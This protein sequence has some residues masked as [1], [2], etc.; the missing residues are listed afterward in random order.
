MATAFIVAYTEGFR[1]RARVCLDSVRKH[2]PSAKLEELVIENPEF[3]K[4][5]YVKGLARL[6][7]IKAREALLRNEGPVV[8]IGADCVFYDSI[9]RLLRVSKR[10]QY[11][12]S[13][14]PHVL[15][16]LPTDELLPNMQ[17]VYKTGHAN[18]D[19]IIFYPNKGAMEI[20]DWLLSVPMENRIEDGIFYEQNW[21]SALPFLFDGV[22]I[23][24]HPGYNVAY[25][26]AHEERDLEDVVFVQYSGYIEGNP[27]MM[28]KHNERF[29]ATG[30]LLE[31]FKEYEEAIK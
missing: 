25:F 23:I 27:A 6:R 31:L 3:E 16:P 10:C 5:G 2:H 1:K 13:I 15:K 12:V 4:G 8:V 24:R 28:S 30:K 7:L 20:I 26:N 14:T 18:A 22:D 21:L 29:R 11:S 19:F 17:G 9:D